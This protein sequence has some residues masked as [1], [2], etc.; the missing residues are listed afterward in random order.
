ME[1][2]KEHQEIKEYDNWFY[3]VLPDEIREK[4]YWIVIHDK[5][6]DW[7]KKFNKYQDSFHTHIT[8]HH[9]D[10]REK[11][12]SIMKKLAGV[13]EEFKGFNSMNRYI[14]CRWI[15]KSDYRLRNGWRIGWV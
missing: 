15:M 13:S 5:I 3:D 10:S 1:Y 4:I 9:T 14:M 8:Y 11:L 6:K 2:Y 12:L 7:G